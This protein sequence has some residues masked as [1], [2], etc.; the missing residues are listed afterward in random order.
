MFAMLKLWYRLATVGSTL[1]LVC[2]AVGAFAADVLD[3]RLSHQK[4]TMLVV[5]TMEKAATGTIRAID[6][7]NGHVT[8]QTPGIDSLVQKGKSRIPLLLQIMRCPSISFDTFVRCY[9][10]CDQIVRAELPGRSVYWY[11]GCSPIRRSGVVV[12]LAPGQQSDTVDF[13]RRVIEDIEKK[14]LEI[15]S[16]PVEHQ[17]SGMEKSPTRHP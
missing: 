11:G 6:V 14:L 15:G 5:E 9:S 3:T 17:T 16:R 7:G 8:V 13:R 12:E 2:S 1:L 10:V 4:Q